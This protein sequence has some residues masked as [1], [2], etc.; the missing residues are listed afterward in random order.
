MEFS[1]ED[2]EVRTFGITYEL[3]DAR[4][5]TWTYRVDEAFQPWMLLELAGWPGGIDHRTFTD[6]VLSFRSMAT[7]EWASDDM[8]REL[9]EARRDKLARGEAGW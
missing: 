1:T 5:G 9:E 2:G 4:S 6:M 7:A 8:I 3:L